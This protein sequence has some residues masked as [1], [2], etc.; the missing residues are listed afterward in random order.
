MKRFRVTLL[1]ICLILGWLGYADLSLLLRNPQP[2]PINISELETTGAPREWLTVTGGH[3]DL[4]QAI[5][6]SGKMEIDSFLVPLKVSPGAEEIRVWFE[7]RDPQIVDLLT[8][9][10]FHLDTD[11]ERST[12]LAENQL[13][14]NAEREL[15]GMTAENLV[16]DSNREK[17]LELLKE[18]NMPTS[19][20]VIFISEGKQ[21][22]MPRGIFFTAMAVIGLLKLLFDLKKS[23]AASPQTPTDAEA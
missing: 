20:D 12:F 11:E 15:T 10:Y 6:M 19:E 9:Y 5:N 13:L 14:L 3:Q 8:R 16:A 21:P 22:A 4:L 2:Q 1:V 17:L 23:S 18:M 7:T